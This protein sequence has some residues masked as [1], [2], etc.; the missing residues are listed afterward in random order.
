M[1][2][3]LD[4]RTLSAICRQVYSRYPAVDGVRPRITRQEDR[5][6]EQFLLLF[7]TTVRTDDGMRLPL[8]VRAVSDEKGK[9]LKLSTSR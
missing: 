4:E 6:R 7:K 5:G 3:G 1:D 9:I 8:T 2:G